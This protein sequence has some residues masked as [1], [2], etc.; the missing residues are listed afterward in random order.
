MKWK[1]RLPEF[2]FRRRRKQIPPSEIFK[3]ELKVQDAF[4]REMTYASIFRWNHEL[5]HGVVLQTG[6]TEYDSQGASAQVTIGAAK[7]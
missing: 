7:K 1:S 4:G 6:V 2:L 3:V 5:R